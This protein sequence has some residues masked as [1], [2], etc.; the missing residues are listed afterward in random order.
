MIMSVLNLPPIIAGFFTTKIDKKAESTSLVGT[1]QKIR[2]VI[3]EHID[4]GLTHFVLD[5]VGLDEDTIKIVD[6]K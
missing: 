1:P 5:L 4:L 2:M 6:S 3:N